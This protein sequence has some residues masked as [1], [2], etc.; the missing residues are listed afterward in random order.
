MPRPNTAFR[1]ELK[2]AR[3]VARQ[4]EKTKEDEAGGSE[5]EPTLRARRQ[6]VYPKYTGST[7]RNQ[8]EFDRGG[9]LSPFVGK[10]LRHSLIFAQF[11]GICPPQRHAARYNGTLRYEKTGAWQ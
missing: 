5:T 7:P 4:A 2:G 1:V 11:A 3:V 6:T 10:C 8:S 9:E